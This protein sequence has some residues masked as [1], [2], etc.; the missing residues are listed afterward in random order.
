MNKKVTIKLAPLRKSISVNPGTPLIDVLHEFGVEFPCGGKGTCGSCKVKLLNGE[1]KVDSVQQ[2]KLAK[3][4][5]GEN[6]RLACYCKAESDITLEISQF[7]N[8]FESNF[9]RFFKRSASFFATANRFADFQPISDEENFDNWK[10]FHRVTVDLVVNCAVLAS[11]SERFIQKCSDRRCYNFE[12]LKI[13]SQT[14]GF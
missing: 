11:F 1:L 14:F 2:Q 7:E 3:L 10:S 13:F 12:F 6:W 9:L 4:K 8:I 5:L